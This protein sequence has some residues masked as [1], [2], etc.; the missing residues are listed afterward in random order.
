MRL[1]I[2]FLLAFTVAAVVGLGSTWLVLTH[3][4]PFGA[5]RAGAWS[6]WPKT[7]TRDI[8]P[9]A[10]AMIARSGELPIAS[11]DGISFLARS[12][13][14]GRPL[15]GR[16]DIAVAGTTPPARYWTLTLYDSQGQLVANALN[17]Y[18][19]TSEEVV[20]SMN[21]DFTITLAPQ[22]RAGNWL[23]TGGVEHYLLMLRLYDTPVGS[24]LQS[25]REV[26]M[27]TVIRKGCP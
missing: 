17:R 14:E 13:D 12:D 6:A 9:Y 25:G 18:G 23:P 5:L 11:G 10:R 24:A 3:G 26:T 19:F 21:G 15:D 4:T 27:P 22:A 1:L 2:G 8:D 7:G 20:R 16:C